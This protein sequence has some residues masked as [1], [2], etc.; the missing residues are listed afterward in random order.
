ML[1]TVWSEF[2]ISVTEVGSNKLHLL[3]YI[4]LNKFWGKSTFKSAFITPYFSLEYICEEELLLLLHYI[5]QYLTFY[6]LKIIN[7]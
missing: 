4:N 3:H 5:W 1:V 2:E 7:F 6:F